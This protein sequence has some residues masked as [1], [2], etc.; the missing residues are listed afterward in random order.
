MKN[1]ESEGFPFFLYSS[2]HHISS[3]ELEVRIS[4]LGRRETTINFK[5]RG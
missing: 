4:R 5:R 1:R 2:S 3:E